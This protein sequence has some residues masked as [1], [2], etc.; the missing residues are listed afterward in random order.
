MSITANWRS[1][2]MDLKVEIPLHYVIIS[3]FIGYLYFYLYQTGYK[4]IISW[5]SFKLGCISGF[6]LSTIAV[7]VGLISSNAFTWDEFI[8]S[9]I[10]IGIQCM[11]IGVILVMVGG[12]FAI[13]VKR[14]LSNFKHE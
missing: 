8:S 7:F 13:T 6:T 12:V 3:L 2:Y 10:E 1:I 4:R 14:I 5:T 11:V 9:S